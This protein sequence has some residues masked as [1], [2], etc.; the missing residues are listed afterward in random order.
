M[1]P[2]Q[3][4]ALLS[5]GRDMWQQLPSGRTRGREVGEI[6]KRNYLVETF[7]DQIDCKL[8]ADPIDPD[9]ILFSNGFREE[10]SQPGRHVIHLLQQHWEGKG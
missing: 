3:V 9:N 5:D 10:G 6:R 1:A 4:A 8:M 7:G 2:C